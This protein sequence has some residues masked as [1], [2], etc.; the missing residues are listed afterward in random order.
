MV[1]KR[2]LC[3]LE[4][5][6]WLLRVLWIVIT[7]V[8][9]WLWAASEAS[10]SAW[11]LCGCAHCCAASPQSVWDVATA[12]STCL[13]CG[14][15]VLMWGGLNGVPL[16]RLDNWSALPHSYPFLSAVCMFVH[17]YSAVTTSSL[18]KSEENSL[19][20]R[21]VSLTEAWS[22][23]DTHSCLWI[24][25]GQNVGVRKASAFLPA[26]HKSITCSLLVAQTT[27][28]CASRCCAPCREDLVIVVQQR[29]RVYEV[30][31]HTTVVLSFNFPPRRRLLALTEDPNKHVGAVV[32]FLSIATLESED[33]VSG[34]KCVIRKVK[35]N[36]TTWFDNKS[37]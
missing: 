2:P 4:G 10:S 16:W 5:L 34:V 27:E 11:L 17:E 29:V 35:S 8:W 23:P 26:Q 18:P 19:T 15:L 25:K 28:R 6:W 13:L 33:S 32:A 36:H 20:H 12:V 31:S 21:P 1:E 9:D 30:A 14:V 22:F 37:N 3:T 24:A 7:P